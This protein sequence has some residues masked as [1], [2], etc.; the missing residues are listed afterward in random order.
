MASQGRA[1]N[2]LELEVYSESQVQTGYLPCPPT[3]R[4]LDVLNNRFFENASG[5]ESFI[6]LI[7]PG[8]AAG[9]DSATL[10]FRKSAIE[11]IA[12]TDANTGR[13]IGSTPERKNYPFVS[14]M[15][16]RVAIR[17]PSYTVMG[18]LSCA[19][20]QNI[21]TVL[22][23]RKTFLPLTEAT[24]TDCSGQGLMRPFV[25][26]NRHRIISVREEPHPP[27]I[28]TRALSL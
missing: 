17:L 15:F 14:K 2:L 12:L 27:K 24:V 6:G 28:V 19:S 10:C 20:D 5:D 3:L 18:N 11:L 16:R 1:E 8:P 7:E 22:N 25:A 9:Q 21:M 26:I 13:G 23:E 4:V